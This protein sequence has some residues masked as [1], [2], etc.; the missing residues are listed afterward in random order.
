MTPIVFC[1]S[2]VPCARDT[3]ERVKTCPM[4]KPPRSFGNTGRFVI[5][6]A[7]RVDR[8]DTSAGDHRA[9]RTRG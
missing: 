4:R 2:F 7:M 3:I 6:Y 1:A 5:R 8:N 9:T